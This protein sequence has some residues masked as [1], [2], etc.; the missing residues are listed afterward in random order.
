MNLKNIN[1]ILLLVAAG[2]AFYFYIK[3][4]KSNKETA[5]QSNNEIETASQSTQTQSL[6]GETKKQSSPGETKKQTISLT[7]ILKP[8]SKGLEVKL[9][10]IYL[11]QY[12]KALKKVQ[13]VVDGNFGKDTSIALNWLFKKKQTT[14]QEVKNFSIARGLDW[15]I[16]KKIAKQILAQ[17]QININTETF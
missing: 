16:M 7:K 12:L 6:P 17:K 8:G 10:Q 11:N 5:S 1:P 9:L 13:L 2:G 3:K 14:L 15:E 4:V